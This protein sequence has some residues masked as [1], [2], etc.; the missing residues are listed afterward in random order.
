MFKFCDGIYTPQFSIE[1]V[2]LF[3]T[4]IDVKPEGALRGEALHRG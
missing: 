1:R 2:P 3:L 4:V